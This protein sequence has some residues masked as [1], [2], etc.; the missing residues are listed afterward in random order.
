MAKVASLAVVEAATCGV[1][2]KLRVGEAKILLSTVKKSDVGTVRV[3]AMASG[4]R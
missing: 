1:Y 4:I 2:V 3:S